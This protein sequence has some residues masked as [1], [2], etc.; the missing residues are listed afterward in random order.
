VPR[1]CR[2][3]QDQRFAALRL[4]DDTR[5]VHSGSHPGEQ[6]GAVNP[7]VYHASTI[8]SATV[9]EWQEQGRQRARDVVGTY[10]GRIG[11]PTTHALE[12]A[13][14]EL[15]GGHRTLLYPSGLAACT[16][17]LSSFLRAGDHALIAD[18]V[19]GPTRHFA[20]AFLS[21]FGV[22][23]EYF[24]PLIGAGIAARMRPNTRVVYLESPG[25]HSFEVQD[26]PAIAAAAHAAGAVVLL[27]NTWATP[28]YFKAFQHGVDVSVQAATKYIVGHSDAMLGSVTA[29]EA[30]WP[31]LRDTYVQ[32]GFSA[33][34][35]DVYLGLRGLRTLA[36]RLQRHW[37]TGVRLAQW[38]ASQPEVER[39]LHP[40]LPDD[41]GH[42]LWRRD[43]RGASGLFGVRLKAAVP[44]RA[45]HALIDSLRLFGLGASWGGFE[46]LVIP[47]D[48]RKV[49]TA[50][51]WTHAGPAFRVHAGL[52]AAE[53]L[54]A[55]LERG[56][57]Q[58]RGAV[59]G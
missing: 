39:V 12:E 47:T 37:D 32:L 16:G 18:C 20:E 29:S 58:L 28:L 46:S 38:I 10:Y 33:A 4:K 27:D 51:P 56:F 13:L 17:A 7:P 31:A 2:A 43:F 57:G 45:L 55:D 54:I 19:Y 48:L 25:S 35:D 3:G 5:V 15:E 52:E 14:T 34:P 22:Q 36:I 59:A 40:A 50:V 41:P 24:D 49:R 53:D 30:H 23:T 6:H 42:A 44:Q 11:T 8:L 1:R 26:V 9:A 21:R